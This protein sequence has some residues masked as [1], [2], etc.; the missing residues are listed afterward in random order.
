MD[1][2]WNWTT[3]I[4]G[5]FDRETST[6]Y[7]YHEHYR[8]HA[9][10]PVH[11]AGIRAAGEWIPGRI[12]PGANGRSQVDGKQLLQLYLDLGLKLD[13]APNGVEAG[14]YEVWTRL[15]AG[16]IRIF[17]SLKHTFTEYRMYRRDAKGR[18]VKKND[19]LMDALRY[20]VA[21]GHEFMEAS[22]VRFETNPYAM[23]STGGSDGWMG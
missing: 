19:H 16:K 12:D 10:P 4:W 20:L 3:A 7:I 21:S 23:R 2:G 8:S 15:T 22:K 11:A 14:I 13:M 6:L 17:S 9:E 1:V 18:I 5:A